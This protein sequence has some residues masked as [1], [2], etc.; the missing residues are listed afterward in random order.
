VF[1]GETRSSRFARMLPDWIQPGY[2]RMAGLNSPT[3]FAT[4]D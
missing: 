4:G 2:R 1:V 3:S